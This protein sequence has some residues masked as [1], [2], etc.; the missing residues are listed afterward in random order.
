MLGFSVQGS[1]CHT[2]VNCH[3]LL[4]NIITTG[5]TF[6]NKV[7]QQLHDHVKKNAIF[8]LTN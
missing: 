6:N 3:H 2:G 4:Y 8:Y 1:P 5:T 7:K